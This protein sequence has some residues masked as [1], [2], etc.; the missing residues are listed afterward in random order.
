MSVA[1]INVNIK[2]RGRD[3][4]CLLL[5]KKQKEQVCIC[6]Q[7]ILRFVSLLQ[8]VRSGTLS[9][10]PSLSGKHPPTSASFFSASWPRPKGTDL[11]LFLFFVN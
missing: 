2:P 1:L 10:L 11:L 4:V 5:E 6:I 8:G 3:C 7:D 9:F